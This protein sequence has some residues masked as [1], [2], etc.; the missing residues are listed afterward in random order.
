M[1]SKRDAFGLMMVLLMVCSVGRPQTSFT[2]VER[3]LLATLHTMNVQ[4]SLVPGSVQFDQGASR[5]I[6]NDRD[7]VVER[8][9]ISGL[10]MEAR[11][12][13]KPLTACLPFYA[14]ADLRFANED[15]VQRSWP[16]E[17]SSKLTSREA[18]KP[19]DSVL[20][21]L[22]TNGI[23]ILMRAV[24]LQH[25]YVGQMTRVRAV[26]GRHEVMRGRVFADHVVRSES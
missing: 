5:R 20:F 2:V 1:R 24:A 6:L 19:G 26:D 13:C 22:N 23:R 15:I 16:I 10:K 12:R 3:A 21:I 9:S 7:L 25:S 18:L 8:A 14:S 4:A 17:T 11:L